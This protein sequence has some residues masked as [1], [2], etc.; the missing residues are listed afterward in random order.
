MSSKRRLWPGAMPC[1]HKTP[2]TE[3]TIGRRKRR[4]QHSN[5]RLM[6]ELLSESNDAINPL[7]EN[8]SEAEI[9]QE[10]EHYEEHQSQSSSTN[11]CH[12]KTA[13]R[14][15]DDDILDVESSEAV[16]DELTNLK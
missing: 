16:I 14:R 12:T 3:A 13:D 2:E 5:K 6:V 9:E 10:D 11:T 4:D 7:E 1:M 8:V 15:I